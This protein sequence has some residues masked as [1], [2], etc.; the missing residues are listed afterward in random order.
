MRI[1]YVVFAWLF[2]VSILASFFFFVLHEG[3][4]LWCPPPAA[5]LD[6]R[7]ILQE[8]CGLLCFFA[9]VFVAGCLNVRGGSNVLSGPLCLQQVLTNNH[10]KVD[11]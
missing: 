2:F 3:S 1:D 8:L 7:Y 4:L 9:V 6:N 5:S 11:V 10:V